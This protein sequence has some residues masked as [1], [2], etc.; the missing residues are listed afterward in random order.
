MLIR[1]LFHF[2]LGLPIWNNLKAIFKSLP[3]SRLKLSSTDATTNRAVFD[4]LRQLRANQNGTLKITWTATVNI[5]DFGHC[6]VPISTA[7]DAQSTY[8]TLKYFS[9]VN[10]VENAADQYVV[11]HEENV[12]AVEIS[13]LEELLNRDVN[14]DQSTKKEETRVAI[15][16]LPQ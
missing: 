10:N 11:N 2:D 4:V 9:H 16:I 7:A 5:D 6:F 8:F 14:M 13:T 12:V 3:L 1:F 15:Q